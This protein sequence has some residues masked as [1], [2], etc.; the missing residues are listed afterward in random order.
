MFLYDTMRTG[1]GRLLR[2]W[3]SGAQAKYNGYLEDYAYLADG[4]LALYQTTFDDRWFVWAQELADMM[5]AHF[6]DEDGGFY[7]TSDDHED[8]FYRPKDVQD[9]AIPSANAMAAQVLLKLSLYTGDGN[10]WEVAEKMVASMYGAMAQYPT[11]FGHWLGA[12]AF[13]L[14][15]PQEVAIIGD[16]GLADTEALIDA[17]FA[18]YRP[19]LVVA[20][21]GSGK[22]I[23]LL[24]DRKFIERRA[25]AYVCRR[26]VCQQPVT[27]PKA[28]ADQLNE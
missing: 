28:L 1:N 10:Y 5:L 24:H 6:A 21:G 15:E 22:T 23:P 8:L 25:T 18:C 9:N 16:H 26:F 7:D 4:L 20:V 2:T 11:G 14:G 17:V 27:D 19:N 13:L 3:K 12:A